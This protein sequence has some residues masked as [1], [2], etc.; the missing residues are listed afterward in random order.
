MS[1][2]L[3]CATYRRPSSDSLSLSLHSQKDQLSSPLLDNYPRLRLSRLIQT[4]SPVPILDAFIGIAVE[5]AVSFTPGYLDPRRGKIEHDVNQLRWLRQ[6]AVDGRGKRVYPLRP[7]GIGSPQ[8]T[9]ALATI[10]AL[11]SALLELS[12]VLIVVDPAIMCRDMR[13]AFNFESISLCH[14]ID[15]IAA[16]ACGFAANGAIATHVGIRGVRHSSKL[17]PAAVAGTLDFHSTPP[18][19]RSRYCIKVD[20]HILPRTSSTIDAPYSSV[21][22]R[23]SVCNL[24]SPPLPAMENHRTFLLCV[25][26]E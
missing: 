1:S 8:G 17:Y 4:V 10:V 19:R 14:D 7:G 12:R 18:N 3:T 20:S 15:P 22:H 23:S 2:R 9:A 24:I 5:M 13:L 6:L 25:Y 11:A 26:Q 21:N 16:P